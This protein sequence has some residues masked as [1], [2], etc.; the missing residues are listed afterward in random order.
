MLYRGSDLTVSQKHF[1]VAAPFL[2]GADRVHFCQ[3]D[4]K[5]FFSI[6]TEINIAV[7]FI[8]RGLHLHRRSSAHSCLMEFRFVYAPNSIE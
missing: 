3:V 1:A 4:T 8:C 2:D 5:V 7:V 6:V